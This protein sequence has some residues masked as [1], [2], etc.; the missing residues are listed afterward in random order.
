[1]EDTIQF[2]IQTVYNQL[3]PS[4]KKVADYILN[5]N[6]SIE[7]LSMSLIEK[8]VG[9]SQPTI[10]R[11]VKAIE[12][13]GFKQLKYH[14]IKSNE[15]HTHFLYGFDITQLSKIQ[16]IPSLMIA[17]TIQMLEDT[18]K[19]IS[20]DSFEKAV[21]M[22]HNAQH[23]SIYAVEN[24]ASVAVDLM[25]KLLYLGKDVHYYNDYYLQNINA[26]NLSQ[27]DI[28]IGISYSGNSVNTIETLKLAHKSQAHTIT[29]SNFE[30]ALIH[31]YGDVSLY[32]SQKQYLYGDAIYSR[33]TQTSIID[34]LYV[35]ILFCD[36]QKYTKKLDTY[37]QLIKKR[38]F[39]KE[40]QKM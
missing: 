17:T 20:V 24:S 30:N 38:G 36:Y 40:D 6:N 37:S 14:L 26:Q 18:L 35:G 11:F 16:D 5:Y 15:T 39:Q 31:Q 29:I 12:Y 3:R 13:K 22:L 33:T 32:T 10:M 7:T 25:T 2:Q 21:R 27:D 34:M 8:E 19:S 1:M 4:E 9:V 23:I 28:A